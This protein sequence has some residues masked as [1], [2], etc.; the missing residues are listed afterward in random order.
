MVFIYRMKFLDR[1]LQSWRTNKAIKH[2]NKD[3]VVLDIGCYDAI[4]FEKLGSKI[5]FGIGMDPLIE[6]LQSEN[7]QLINGLF[8]QK[9]PSDIQIFDAIVLL[10]VLEHI[11]ETEIE[12]LISQIFNHLKPKGKVILTVP[13][14]KVDT[15]LHYLI[16]FKILDG[17]SVE[18]HHGF[19]TKKT[20][21]YFEKKGLKLLKHETFQLG[22]NN[23]FV[24]IKD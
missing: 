5:K 7:Y 2:I 6:P 19:D 9:L 12:N 15:I 14:P 13:D 22:L 23:L 21:P 20:I 17:M 24:F 8:P 10:A 16:K 3:D 1:F 4:L 11:P 18:E